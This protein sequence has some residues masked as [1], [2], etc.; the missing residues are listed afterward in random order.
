MSSINSEKLKN[1]RAPV[2]IA[3]IG[4]GIIADVRHMPALMAHL[5]NH[6]HDG[7]LLAVVEPDA[8]R[9]ENMQNK[10]RFPRAYSD[11]P[12]MLQEVKPDAVLVITPWWINGKVAAQVLA[13]GIH[14]FMEKPPGMSTE[15]VHLLVELAQKY[16]LVGQVGYNRR[17]WPALQKGLEW[18]RESGDPIQYMRGT[19]HRTNRINEHYTFYTSSHVIDFLLSVSGEPVAMHSIRQPIP[20]KQPMATG[21]IHHPMPGTEQA[22]NFIT[23]IQFKNGSVAH[24]TGFPHVSFNQE[25]YEFHTCDSTV[26]VDQNWGLDKPAVVRQYRKYE[27]VR[28]LFFSK[29]EETLYTD[30]YV[31]Q[32]QVFFNALLRGGKP[33]PSFVDCVRTIELVEAIQHDKPWSVNT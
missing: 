2:K 16:G 10:Y 19:K 28:E 18:V 25:L 14:V 29:G 8:S 3:L 1:I 5:K 22:F 27:L 11:I 6:P 17:H 9:R 30:G 7:E 4:A 32:L 31:G 26:I 15:E 20:G 24:A 33:Y 23:T 21:P 12:A 13:E